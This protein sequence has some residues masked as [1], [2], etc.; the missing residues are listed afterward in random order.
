MAIKRQNQE[1]FPL[2]FTKLTLFAEF[3]SCLA[4][5]FCQEF[6]NWADADRNGRPGLS[7]FNEGDAC[8]IQ[9]SQRYVASCSTFRKGY[10]TVNIWGKIGL[11]LVYLKG[12]VLSPKEHSHHQPSIVSLGS[13]LGSLALPIFE[14]SGGT[15][16]QHLHHVIQWSLLFRPNLWCT[17]KLVARLGRGELLRFA[18]HLGFQGSAKDLDKDSGT[19]G[20]RELHLN[21]T[22]LLEYPITVVTSTGIPKLRIFLEKQPDVVA[23]TLVT[24]GGVWIYGSAVPLGFLLWWLSR[25]PRRLWFVA[26]FTDAGGYGG[27]LFLRWRRFAAGAPMDR[28][29]ESFFFLGKW[30]D[31]M[32]GIGEMHRHAKT[33]ELLAYGQEKV[34]IDQVSHSYSDIHIIPN[35]MIVY[36]TNN[37]GHWIILAIWQYPS[38]HCSM[39]NDILK[40][41]VGWV[42]DGD[43]SSLLLTDGEQGGALDSRFSTIER[44]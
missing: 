22:V 5:E 42:R 38:C 1:F 20:C 30:N 34:A 8:R 33:W 4:W 43:M 28:V 13:W 41:G 19:D 17:A 24:P 29:I 35:N 7:D 10:Q 9:R 15:F 31:V 25:Q 39:L 14:H 3:M 27:L 12:V 6:F 32:S 36:V 26:I 37:S 23:S 11:R 44:A 21:Y 16:L 18:K 40:G 2:N